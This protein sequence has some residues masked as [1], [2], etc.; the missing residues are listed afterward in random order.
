MYL[1]IVYMVLIPGLEGLLGWERL[2]L[3][4]QCDYVEMIKCLMIK[5]FSFAGHLPVHLYSQ[6]MI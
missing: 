5:K 2:P 3:S 6:F 1:V 4:G